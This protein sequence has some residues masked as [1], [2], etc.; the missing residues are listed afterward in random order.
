MSQADY[1]LAFQDGLVVES[2][3]PEDDDDLDERYTL[4]VH[5]LGELVVISGQIVACDPLSMPDMPPFAE[6]VAPG[7]C[8]VLIS[9]AE[10]A[11]GDQR[12][13]FAL[14]RLSD[15]PAARWEN[16]VPQGK[17]L[18][19]LKAGDVFGY[20]VD[21]GTGCFM[22]VATARALVALAKAA[23]A[24]GDYEDN[25]GLT[26]ALMATYVNTWSWANLVVD[27]ASGA[28]VI[29]FSSGWGDGW[30]ASYW[31]YDISDQRVALITDFGVVDPTWLSHK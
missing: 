10:S 14:L 5:D 8:S 20:G 31:G 17:S 11:S 26:D 28:N 30:Y 3:N 7:R 16:A 12:V 24:R 21:A 6:T 19:E 23:A 18:G 9:V 1:G 4:Q 29:A 27:P 25:S 22:D 2:P 15:R 13:A